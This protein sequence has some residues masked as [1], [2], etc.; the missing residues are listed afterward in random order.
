VNKVSN[1]LLGKGSN[2]RPWGRGRGRGGGGY[3]RYGAQ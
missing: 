2:R 3:R 1:F